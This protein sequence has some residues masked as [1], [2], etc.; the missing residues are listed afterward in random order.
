[1]R[2]LADESVHEVIVA[3]VRS[4]D[5]DLVTVAALNRSLLDP[6]VVRLAD[7]EQRLLL[8]D[9]KDFGYLVVRQRMGTP[10]VVLLRLHGLPL[11]QRAA[12][13]LEAIATYGERFIGS[14]TVIQRRQ[15][16]IR[17]LIRGGAQPVT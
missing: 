3:A 9:D 7:R 1:M 17:P 13:L 12:I 4:A 5:E 8:T 14:F 10:G 11:E 6:D 2:W 15:V 16:R